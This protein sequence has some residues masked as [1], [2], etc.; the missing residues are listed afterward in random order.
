MS[1]EC[2]SR[3]AAF[4]TSVWLAATLI[5]GVACGGD[6]YRHPVAE[7]AFEEARRKTPDE[8]VAS[9][10]DRPLGLD[11]FQR[12]WEDHADRRASEA[13]E[14]RL[15]REVAVQKSLEEGALDGRRLQLAR[16]RA[17]VQLLL[18]RTVEREVTADSIDSE[19]VEKFEEGIRRRHGRP[20]GLQVSHVAVA[21]PEKLRS[22]DAPS[23]EREEAQQKARTW[24]ERIREEL[25]EEADLPAFFRVRDEFE[26]RLPGD[27]RVVVN[28]HIRFP[29][30]SSRTF[31]GKL[32]AGWSNVV[33]GLA[34]EAERL[35]DEGKFGRISE[36]VSSRFGWHVLRVERELEG[37][38]PDPE[39]LRKFA[40]WRAV[41]RERRKKLQQKLQSW[42]QGMAIWADPGAV[43]ESE[44]D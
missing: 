39:A 11:S 8:S 20:A 10:G 2:D 34:A 44:G 28:A 43:E 14:G 24:I 23:E 40:T 19:V 22:R 17:M 31:E 29:R 3:W 12:F 16:K 35:A 38:V 30:P 9:V 1:S 42:R 33:S 41:R 32:P 36:P 6:D 27:L 4:V 5:F 7:S 13:V 25:P 37:R 15:E 18:R 21:L 26:G